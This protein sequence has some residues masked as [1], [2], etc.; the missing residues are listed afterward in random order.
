MERLS[1]RPWI[2]TVG[3]LL[4]AAGRACAESID[5]LGLWTAL[6]AQG[7]VDRVAAVDERLK[8]WFDGHL[9][10]LDDADGIHQSIVR[11]G[12]GWAI[13]EQSTVWA[14]YAWVRTSPI[15]GPDF[16][17]NRI[18]QQWTW[19]DDFGVWNLGQR[20]RFEQRFLETGD[21]VG[22]RYRQFFRA[23]RRLPAW[24]GMSLVAWDELFFHLNDT[25]WGARS[26]FDQNRVFV[27]VGYKPASAGRWR[28]EVGYLNQVID[29][30]AGADRVNHIL[31]LNFF[32]SP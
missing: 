22:L 18:W 16:D 28:V 6:F 10:F 29:V 12:L 25:D 1:A 26:G 14:G 32:R 11:P 17:E 27:G 3:V 9:R 5:D 23:Q 30:A 2:T 15:S 13:D 21:D 31:A 8:W 19:S 20:A 24:A 7:D 4:L